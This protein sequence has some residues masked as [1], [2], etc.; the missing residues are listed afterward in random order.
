MEPQIND[1]S[2]AQISPVNETNQFHNGFISSNSSVGTKELT[3][4]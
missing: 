3:N 1:E 2:E 4:E